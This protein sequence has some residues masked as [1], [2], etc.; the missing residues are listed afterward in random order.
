MRMRDQMVE[1]EL[2]GTALATRTGAKVLQERD[3]NR[4]ARV[5][6]VAYIITLLPALVQAQGRT[7]RTD[8]AAI[9]GEAGLFL[10]RADDLASGLDLFGSYEC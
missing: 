9:G 7:P 8:S 6:C 3:M 1:L 10:P 4:I 5:C 2:C